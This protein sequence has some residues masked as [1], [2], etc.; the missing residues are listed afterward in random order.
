L[1]FPGGNNWEYYPDTGAWV[2]DK[3]NQPN[4]PGFNPSPYIVPAV[5]IAGEAA[6]AYGIW[7]LIETFWWA[8]A[9]AL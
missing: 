3:Q 2:P 8:P 9:V 5:A 1:E 6:A 7:W 4:R